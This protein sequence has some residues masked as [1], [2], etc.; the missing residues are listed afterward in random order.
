MR[1]LI[2]WDMITLDGFF[3]GPNKG[4]IDWFLFEEEE[5]EPYI[6]ESQMRAG[7]LLFGRVTYEGMAEYWRS[8]EGTIA[9][10]MNSVEKVVFSRTLESAD[11][12]NTRLVK[13][14]AAEEV[15][16]L[17]GQDGRAIFVFGSA[18]FTSTLIE[19]DLID[20]Y[21]IGINPLLLGTGTPFFKGSK[22]RVDLKL[23]EAR[24]LKSGLVILHYQPA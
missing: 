1:K 21:R 22:R 6:L 11:W 9:E 3:E 5:L 13:D 18:D 16:K 10:F 4:D 24:P 8:A 7:T 14:N 15:S 20:E 17:K 12:S 19:H 2:A 23:V